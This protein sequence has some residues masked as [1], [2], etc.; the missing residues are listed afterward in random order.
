MSDKPPTD[1]GHTIHTVNTRQVQKTNDTAKKER[2]ELLRIIESQQAQVDAALALSQ[3]AVDFRP[4]RK[5]KTGRS[6]SAVACAI[7]SDWHVEEPVRSESVNGLN[8]FNLE[9]AEARIESFFKST[10]KLVE[11]QRHG[12]KIDKLVL[13]LLGDFMTGF[14]H[15]ELMQTNELTPTETVLWLMEQLGSGLKFLE[16]HFEE[17]ILPCCYGNH[18]RTTVKSRH[19]T[20]PRMS[21]EWMMYHLLAKQF[22]QFTW[23]IADSYHHYVEVDGRKIRFHHGDGLKYQGG[24]GGLTIPVEKAIASWNKGITAYLDVF[25]HWHTSL[26]TNKFVSNGSLIGYNAYAVSIKAAYEPPSQSF[27]L[28]DKD[29]GKTI[30]APIFLD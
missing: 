30:S 10:V 23:E 25:G 1:W 17:I 29:R 20:G 5:I 22:P 15:E 11:I 27:F 2:E 24:V 19:A 7:A 3:G 12:T 9:V 4:I 8:K 18:G 13:G 14:I 26:Q 6:G 16:P 28:L 21:Y